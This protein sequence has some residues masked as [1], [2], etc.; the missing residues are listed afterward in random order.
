MIVK[1]EKK[2]EK[3]RDWVHHHDIP[4]GSKEKITI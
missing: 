3:S 4:C 1:N 2:M